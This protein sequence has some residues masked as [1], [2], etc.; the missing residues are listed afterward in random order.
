MPPKQ[1]FT[2]IP[3]RHVTSH[4][5]TEQRSVIED[6]FG[7]NEPWMITAVCA[8][9][10]DPDA[11]YPEKG[12]PTQKGKAVCG[13]CD[14]RAACLAYALDRN[15]PYGIWGGLSVRERRRLQRDPSLRAAIL[16][17]LQLPPPGL[18]EP[19]A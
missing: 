14:V 12:G 10:D 4:G 18:Q 7:N 13:R 2:A 3:A 17:S 15:E 11:F 16:T 9:T 5:H 19:A 8:Q 1:H 6:L